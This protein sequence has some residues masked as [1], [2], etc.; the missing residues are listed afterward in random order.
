MFTTTTEMH[1]LNARLDLIPAEQILDSSK[2]DGFS[3]VLFF[4][5]I[6][7]IEKFA[8]EPLRQTADLVKQVSAIITRS[9]E[10]E[11]PHFSQFS[12]SSL[13]LYR[14]KKNIAHSSGYPLK[15]FHLLI[16]NFR[17]YNNIMFTS[18]S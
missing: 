18:K 12:V 8:D 5:N 16:H 7:A 3:N 15:T 17:N 13:T 11:L 1:G 9:R 2:N 4:S 10:P 14:Q 6:E